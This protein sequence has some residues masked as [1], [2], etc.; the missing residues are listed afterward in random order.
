MDILK[1]FPSQNWTEYLVSSKIELSFPSANKK[2]DFLGQLEADLLSLLHKNR[3]KPAIDRISLGLHLDTQYFLSHLKKSGVLRHSTYVER[4][5]PISKIVNH[6]LEFQKLYQ[7]Q[8]RD[9]A[10]LQSLLNFERVY[11]EMKAVHS[12]TLRELKIISKPTVSNIDGRN[13]TSSKLRGLMARADMAFLTKGQPDR[14]SL[15]LTNIAY[16]AKEEVSEAVSF[17]VAKYNELHG[18]KDVDFKLTDSKY[19]DSL[20]VEILI[21]EACRYK[22]LVEL[23]IQIESFGFDCI[24]DGETVLISHQDILFAKSIDLSNIQYAQQSLVNTHQIRTSYADAMSIFA[25]AEEIHRRLPNIFKLKTNITERYVMEV[26]HPVYTYWLKPGKLSFFQEEISILVDISREILIPTKNLE[27]YELK[28][29]LSFSDFLLFLKFFLLQYALF[30]VKLRELVGTVDNKII[31]NSLIA[32]VTRPVLQKTLELLGSTDK[33][34]LFLELISWNTQDTSA[35]VDLQYKP[36]LTKKDLIIAP[37]CILGVSNLPRNIFAAE[38]KKG[39]NIKKLQ[40]KHHI[41]IATILERI[42]KKRGFMIKKNVAVKFSTPDQHESD[43]DFLA[44]RDGILLFL[45]C[46]DILH[47]TDVFEMRTTYEHVKKAGSQLSYI[48]KA[49]ADD[50]FLTSFC[51]SHG[52]DKSEIK[53]MKGV[54]VLATNKFWGYSY[55][56]FPIRNFRELYAFINSGTWDFDIGDDNIF[57]FLLWK[58]SFLDSESLLEYLSLNGPHSTMYNA[59]KA[60]KL[61]YGKGIY[62]TSY[63]LLLDVGVENLRVKYRYEEPSGPTEESD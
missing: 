7:L 21:R 20:T 46:K 43:I 57:R 42:F 18:I 28:P 59:C 29:G 48:N 27:T 51:H 22:A 54:I 4:V 53:E 52:I 8:P 49:L 63:S 38:N 39:N 61:N 1:S 9:V 34:N 24:L 6:I 3:I 26:P 44:Y 36:L 50:S 56:G 60:N 33:V 41:T 2:K 30:V 32:A 55:Q 13:I 14:L 5:N 12:H 37:S 19:A 58:E 45:E 47:P 40:E 23:E 10:Y 16:Y 31:Y 11:M 25:A 15:D 35:F 62:K 17:L